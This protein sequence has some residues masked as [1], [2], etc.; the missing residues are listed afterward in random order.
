MFH[1]VRLSVRH[2]RISLKLREIDLWLLGYLNR[3]L[4]FLIQNLPSD[5]RSEVWFCNFECFQVTFSDKLHRKSGTTL[6]TVAG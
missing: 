6:G 2:M 5:L 4:G 1:V 3:N